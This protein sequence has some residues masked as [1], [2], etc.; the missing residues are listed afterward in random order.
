MDILAFIFEFNRYPSGTQELV[1]DPAA[2]EK[3]VIGQP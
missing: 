2:L 3:I 1:A